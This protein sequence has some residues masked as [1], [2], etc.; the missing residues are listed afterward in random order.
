MYAIVVLWWIHMTPLLI[1][2]E[3]FSFNLIKRSNSFANEIIILLNDIRLFFKLFCLN[4]KIEAS[5]CTYGNAS[6]KTNMLSTL[7]NIEPLI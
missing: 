3:I 6:K 5:Y 1:L 2:S 7:E 4:R